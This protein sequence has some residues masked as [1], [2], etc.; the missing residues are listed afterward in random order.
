MNK[1]LIALPIL[2]S[3]L[4]SFNCSAK[5]QYVAQNDLGTEYYI[6]NSSIKKNNGYVYYWVIANYLKPS[7]TGDLSSKSLEQLDCNVPRKQKVLSAIFYTGPM[8]TENS[9]Q[10]SQETMN[11]QDWRYFAPNSTMTK[12]I[13]YVCSLF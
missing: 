9:V 8:G 1:L 10:I 12:V 13:D 7:A 4:L 6:E 11:K 2:F 5:W 3:V